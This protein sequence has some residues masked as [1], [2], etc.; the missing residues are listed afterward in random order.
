MKILV[1]RRVWQE[2]DGKD[3]EQ[4]SQVGAVGIHQDLCEAGCKVVDIGCGGGAN[5]AKWLD[6]CVN[7]HVTGLDYSE[8]SVAE[9]GS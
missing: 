8:V 7:G 2:I 1:S 3:D 5:I 6:K 9:S 4:W